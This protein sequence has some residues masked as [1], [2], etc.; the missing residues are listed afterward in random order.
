M[1]TYKNERQ[2]KLGDW[3]IDTRT[4]HRV[5][6]T[7]LHP[8]N[9]LMKN[10]EHYLHEECHAKQGVVQNTVEKVKRIFQ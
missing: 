5:Q 3:V 2:P 6:I 1:K 4:G 7:S 10:L 9:P 8:N